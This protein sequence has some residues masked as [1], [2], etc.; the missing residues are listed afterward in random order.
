M[1]IKVQ[2]RAKSPPERFAIALPTT[3]DV[4]NLTFRIHHKPSTTKVVTTNG[5]SLLF[6]NP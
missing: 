4:A 2:K 1:S 5:R 6:G 3:P